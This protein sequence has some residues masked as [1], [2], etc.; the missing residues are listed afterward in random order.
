MPRPYKSY[1]L[2]RAPAYF[3]NDYRD[4]VKLLE[5][6]L[7]NYIRL[8]SRLRSHIG[9]RR[10]FLENKHDAI[11]INLIEFSERYRVK[12]IDPNFEGYCLKF[13]ELLRPV[14]L[15]FVKE[16]GYNARG[17]T[18][19]FRLG[20]KLFERNQTVILLKEDHKY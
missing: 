11:H 1:P 7:H 15:D 6:K 14:L 2:E 19:H 9:N 3:E 5:E 16:I 18:Y 20:P 10:R 13:M 4:V 12:F 17:F 8:N